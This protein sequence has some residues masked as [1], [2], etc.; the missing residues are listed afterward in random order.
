MA[1]QA[2]IAQPSVERFDVAVFHRFAWPD[3]V[4]LHAVLI[5]P[6]IHGLAREFSAIV[7]REAVM[8]GD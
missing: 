5:C 2:F 6:Y 1:V 8:G 7:H 4:E 3:E